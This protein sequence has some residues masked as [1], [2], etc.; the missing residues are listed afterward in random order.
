MSWVV[1]SL[2]PFPLPLPRNLN[3]RY[4]S[5]ISSARPPPL[6]ESESDLVWRSRFCAKRICNS[7]HPEA[8]RAL[9]LELSPCPCVTRGPI[10]LYAASKHIFVLIGLCCGICCGRSTL[11]PRIHQS[12]RDRVWASFHIW[13]AFHLPNWTQMWYDISPQLTPIWNA[14]QMR[15]RRD[16]WIRGWTACLGEFILES[17]WRSSNE[18]MAL[19]LEVHFWI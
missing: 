2:S 14:A 5:L 6:S 18:Q 15:S 11:Q 9:K 19:G 17:T 8:V 7:K 12:R 13:A 16:W 3:C 4:Y 1:A 10:I